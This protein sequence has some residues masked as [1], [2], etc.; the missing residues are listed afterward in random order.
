MV[1]VFCSPFSK[2]KIIILFRKDG[3]EYIKVPK[4]FNLRTINSQVDSIF[5]CAVQ[6]MCM[7]ECFVVSKIS[8]VFSVDKQVKIFGTLFQTWHQSCLQSTKT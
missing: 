1:L 8:D 3:T 7:N 6:K 2:Y 4:N 5:F